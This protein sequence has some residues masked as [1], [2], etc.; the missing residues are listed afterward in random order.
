MKNWLYKLLGKEPKPIRKKVQIDMK[1]ETSVFK[2]G[3]HQM[4]KQET[5]EQTKE[6]CKSEDETVQDKT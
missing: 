4:F 3:P 5:T 1:F 2:A 6:I